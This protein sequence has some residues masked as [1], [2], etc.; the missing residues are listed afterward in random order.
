[1]GDSIQLAFPNEYF[2]S[3]TVF[4]PGSSLRLGTIDRRLLISGGALLSS[5]FGV[6][7]W[8]TVSPSIPAPIPFA[9]TQAADTDKTS[10][11]G[12][13]VEKTSTPER[14]TQIEWNDRQLETLPDSMEASYKNALEQAQEIAGQNQLTD[15]IN[16]IAGIPKN[17][18]HFAM[19]QQLQDDWSRELLRQAINECQQARV[20]KAIAMLDAIPTTSQLHAH[21][22]ELRQTWSQQGELLNQAIIA[23]RLGNWQ[24]T[25]DAIKQLEGSPMYHSLQIQQ[26]LQQALIRLYEP[27][28]M[29]LQI[30]TS[31]LPAKEAPETIPN[32]PES[33]RPSQTPVAVSENGMPNSF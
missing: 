31:D 32:V 30:A 14:L 7:G 23:K 12:A 4:K 13:S 33:I 17:S 24:E 8:M 26:L 15:A 11:T 9:G 5:A 1:M 3:V 22:S 20:G 6:Y 10:P 28:P 27:D 2:P 25:I 19:A 18:R 21:V 29:L 16:T